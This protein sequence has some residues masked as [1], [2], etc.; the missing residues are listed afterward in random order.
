MLRFYGKRIWYSGEAEEAGARMSFIQK[1]REYNSKALEF[2]YN[3]TNVAGG[4]EVKRMEE[5]K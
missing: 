1:W 4:E 2:M 5:M 3:S